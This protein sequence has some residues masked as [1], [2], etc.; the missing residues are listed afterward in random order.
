MRHLNSLSLQPVTFPSWIFS[1]TFPKVYNPCFTLNKTCVSIS[2]QIKKHEQAEK[3]NKNTFVPHRDAVGIKGAN[4]Y[5]GVSFVH[6]LESLNLVRTRK[7]QPCENQDTPSIFTNLVIEFMN[8]EVSQV[9]VWILTLLL[10]NC[11][12]LCLFLYTDNY[13]SDELFEKLLE[14]RHTS[15]GSQIPLPNTDV[16]S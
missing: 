7:P 3:K 5:L 6:K 10:I 15:G 2:T 13:P 4:V 16:Q 14:M 1:H 11:F 9:W 8:T 12:I